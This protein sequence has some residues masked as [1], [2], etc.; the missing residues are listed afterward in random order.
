M[1]FDKMNEVQ[2]DQSHDKVPP[3][4][5]QVQT[6]TKRTARERNGEE[7]E[8]HKQEIRDMYLTRNGSLKYVMNDLE[9]KW[10]FRRR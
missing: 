6:T 8:S 9:G 1:S 7:W 3:A 5:L 10:D 2:L 4:L